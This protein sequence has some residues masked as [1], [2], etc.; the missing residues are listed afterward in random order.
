MAN[1]TEEFKNKMIENAVKVNKDVSWK[2]EVRREFE[3]DGKLEI[4]IVDLDKSEA[5]IKFLIRGK[6]SKEVILDF[7]DYVL[8]KGDTV[9]IENVNKTVYKL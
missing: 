9:T 2:D 5:A 7:G 1:L 3:I 8:K 6:E 4:Q